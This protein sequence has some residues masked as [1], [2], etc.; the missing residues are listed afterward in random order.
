LVRRTMCLFAEKSYTVAV[1]GCQ[2]T[3]AE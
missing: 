2:Y 3:D 1:H